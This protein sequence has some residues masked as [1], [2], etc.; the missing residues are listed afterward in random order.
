MSEEDVSRVIKAAGGCVLRRPE[1]NNS[2]DYPISPGETLQGN[3][4][5]TF[6][7]NVFSLN[8]CVY[9]LRS[10]WVLPP[11]ILGGNHDSCAVSRVYP[12]SSE[13]TNS[14]LDVYTLNIGTYGRL[15]FGD[16]IT[17]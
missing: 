3:C 5:S 4:A 2:D 9:M 8:A 16:G 12:L 6:I 17:S 11:H 13:S 14:L 1:P 7:F 15:Y 10:G